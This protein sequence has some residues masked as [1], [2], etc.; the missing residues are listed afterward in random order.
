MLNL[1]QHPRHFLRAI[2]FVARWIPAFAG[3]TIIIACTPLEQLHVVPTQ[4]PKIAQ[5]AFL[6]GDGAELPLKSWKAKKRT[7]AV[8]IALHGFND[9][10]R[11]FEGPGNYFATRGITTYA[12]DQRGFGNAPERG[13]WAGE[14]N[15]VSDIRQMVKAAQARHPKTPVFILGES[16]GGAVTIMALTQEGAPEIS[17]V[18]LS[19]PAL[20]NYNPVFN[21]PLWVS[22]HL[23]P[24]KKVTGEG[25]NVQASDNIPMLQELGRDPLVIKATRLDAVYGLMGL[26]N[27]AGTRGPALRVPTLLIYGE[28]DQVVPPGPVHG[29]AKAL[30]TPHVFTVYPEGWHL[31]L[32]DLQREKVWKDLADWLL[33]QN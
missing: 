22:A 31:L 29:F 33:A 10:S 19:A 18:I 11:S 7:R 17:G 14:A 20:W 26:M 4:K 32:R 5:A 28:K 13:I 21:L 15:L 25:L 1:F 23:F 8:V 16:M 30:D 3:M 6:P 27:G 2:G 9:Y 12:Y 24:E